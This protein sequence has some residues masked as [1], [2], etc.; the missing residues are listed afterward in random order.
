METEIAR[1]NISLLRVYQFYSTYT[2]HLIR[3]E[4]IDVIQYADDF[5][6]I[7]NA[8]NESELNSR[9]SQTLR[10]IKINLEK[11]NFQ[12]STEKCKYITI[13]CSPFHNF[14]VY[15][16]DNLI[17]KVNCIKILGIYFDDKINFRRH[18]KEIKD[19]S[20]KY[21]NILKIFNSKRGGAH[22]KS[23]LNV[24]SSIIK[25]RTTYGSICTFNFLKPNIK[26]LKIIH[27]AALRHCLGM[28]K[29]TPITAILGESA[30]WPI[31]YTL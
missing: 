21:V 31:E 4:Y 28:V 14:Q 30:D 20:L 10:K 19:C 22:P 16:F 1:H 12:I 8:N 9:A 5:T 24:Y 18:N 2:L 27:N 13:N 11:L 3:N 17:E 29:S 15:L 7:I 25:S 23:S 26:N 6:F